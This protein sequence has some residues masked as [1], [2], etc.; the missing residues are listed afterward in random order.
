MRVKMKKEEIL[1]IL[2]L[3]ILMV[4]GMYLHF[5]LPEVTRTAMESAVKDNRESVPLPV[6]MYHG[7][8]DD[9]AKTNE[10]F[11]TAKAFEKDLKWLQDHG[12]TTVSMKQLKEF[13]EKGAAL[14]EKP[15]LLTF[16]DGYRNNYTRAFPLLQKYDAKAVISVIGNESDLSSDTIYRGDEIDGG[17]ITWGEAVLMVRSGLIEI[18]N[19]TYDLHRDEGGR[20]GA[21]KL[22]G[23]TD[24]AYRKA[25]TADLGHNQ[26]LIAAATGQ[27]ALVFAWPFGAWPTDGSADQI[28][29]DLGFAGSLTSYQIMNTIRRDDPSTLFG[30]KRFLRTPKFSLSDH[31]PQ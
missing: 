20:K 25:L 5:R 26:D 3:L 4:T 9:P 12:Y 31:L 22:P 2:F 29:K 10:Y 8:I 18:G 1:L 7:I 17:N 30:L 24:A 19:H 11:I 16:D 13:A 28:L 27:P 23:E 15:V 21:D 14:P 6:L